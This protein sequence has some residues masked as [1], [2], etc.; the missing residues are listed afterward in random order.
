MKTI[1]LSIFISIICL[2][3]S[4]EDMQL[5][6][7]VTSICLSPGLVSTL[8]IG[9]GSFQIKRE[10]LFVFSAGISPYFL[11]G[12]SMMVTAGFKWQKNF[13]TNPDH[14]GM[15]YEM[16]IGVDVINTRTSNTFSGSG[17]VERNFVLPNISGGIGYSFIINDKSFFRLSID[18][19]IKPL[20]ANVNIAWYW[21][22][23]NRLRK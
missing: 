8:N 9:F 21:K 13:F 5:N 2:Q 6:Q 7:N 23:E 20:L 17:I 1:I 18:A 14:D 15:Y 3:L 12:R 16:R 22:Y 4:A 10:N 19:G 11:E